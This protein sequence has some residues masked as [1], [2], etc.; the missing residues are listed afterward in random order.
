MQISQEM[1]GCI[2]NCLRCYSV[3]THTLMHHCMEMGGRH[4]APAHVRRMQSCAEACRA[5]AALMLIGC[6]YHARYC[7]LCADVCE[8]CAEE[9]RQ[10]GGMDD[11]VAACLTCAAS[12]R[13]MSL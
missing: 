11:C 4:S 6:E 3:C 12:C 2:D 10:I 5:A 13:A 9:C 8:D 7:G 1:R